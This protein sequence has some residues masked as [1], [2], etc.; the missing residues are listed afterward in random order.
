[1]RAEGRPDGKSR[2]GMGRE[3]DQRTPNRCSV[4]PFCGGKVMSAL[5]ESRPQMTNTSD[6]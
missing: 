2:K 5:G 4:E 1:M 3:D 6:W